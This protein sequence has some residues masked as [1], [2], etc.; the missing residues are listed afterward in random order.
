MSNFSKCEVCPICNKTF[1]MRKQAIGHL[2]SAHSYVE[3]FLPSQYHVEKGSRPPP[4][5]YNIKKNTSKRVHKCY[6]NACMYSASNRNDMYR[7]Y[8][9]AHFKKEILKEFL[10]KGRK[11]CMY[12]DKE[13]KSKRGSLMHIGVVHSVV[14]KFLSPEHHIKKEV[15]SQILRHDEGNVEKSQP[16]YANRGRHLIPKAENVEKIPLASKE[17]H[18]KK[19]YACT[20]S[21]GSRKDM[22]R[23]YSCVHFK[24]EILKELGDRKTCMY[25]NKEFKSKADG[26][27]HIGVVHSVVEKFLG[28]E[29]HIKKGKVEKCQPLQKIPSNRCCACAFSSSSRKTMYGH[30]SRV[31][32]RE[33]ILK[34]LGDRKICL[35]CDKEFKSK[36]DG[37]LHIGVVHS[38]VEKF[39][40][41]K[42]HIKKVR[43]KSK[44]KNKRDHLANVHHMCCK[45]NTSFSNR[46]FLYSHY[47]TKHFDETIEKKYGKWQTNEQICPIC[48]RML[49]VDRWKWIRHIGVTHSVVED[50]LDKKHH[51]PKQ[52]L[53]IHHENETKHLIDPH[54]AKVVDDVSMIMCDNILDIKTEPTDD[55]ESSDDINVFRTEDLIPDN[56]A[57]LNCNLAVKAEDDSEPPV[58]YLD[59]DL[60]VDSQ[61]DI[62]TEALFDSEPEVILRED[63]N[64]IHTSLV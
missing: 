7:H 42:D 12:C 40:E 18:N 48:M 29:H 55:Y 10:K 45:C 13:F 44:N 11:V 64:E 41:H 57:E 38:V 27:L 25:C 32:F 16:Q 30:Y 17:L 20:F 43:T 15:H 52:P 33:E 14:E 24:Q 6:D 53:P 5:R 50:F 47:A 51:I 60:D 63:V 22:Y 56:P 21:S 3:K 1:L 23:H 61:D 49:R 59:V 28:P 37:L 2:A 31:H 58:F 46:Q 36:A 39:L 35:Y 62:K 34:E 9:H 19:C 26:L 8:S 54:V 4:K